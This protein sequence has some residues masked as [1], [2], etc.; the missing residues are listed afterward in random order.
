MQFQPVTPA[1]LHDASQGGNSANSQGGL[2]G[3]PQELTSILITNRPG[4][5]L[6]RERTSSLLGEQH[7]VAAHRA[8]H[9]RGWTK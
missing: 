7:C 9:R 4:M 6:M 2:E 1:P 8:P 3:V 5:T